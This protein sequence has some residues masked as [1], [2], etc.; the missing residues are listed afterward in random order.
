MA[1]GTLTPSGAEGVSERTRRGSDHPPFPVAMSKLA[2]PA[3]RRGSVIR[4][5]LIDRVRAHPDA[6]VV[7]VV[8]PA[9]YGKTTLLRQWADS[10][11]RPFKW[12][13]LDAHDNDP[14]VLLTGVALALEQIVPVEGDVFRLLHAPRH[15]V[16]SIVAE[17]AHAVDRVIGS[18]VLVLDD[19]HLLDDPECQ[20]IL[21]EVVNRLPP[22][23]QV[24]VGSR[25][26]PALPI[27]RLRA[28][29]RVVELGPSDLAMDDREAGQ[30]LTLADIDLG[31]EDIGALNRRVE[32]WPAALYLAAL[33]IAG[34]ADL[35]PTG[36][37]PVGTDR[38][39]VDYL[40]SEVLRRSAA[41]DVEFLVRTSLLEELSGSLCDAVLRTTGSAARLEALERCNLL[42][43]P[44]GHDRTWYRCH[45]L[46][47]EVLRAELHRRD[48]ELIAALRRRAADWYEAHAL[49][50][51]A[52]EQAMALGDGPRVASLATTWAQPFYQQGRA[53]TA[54]RWLDW[55]DEHDLVESRPTLGFTGA[56]AH[57][58]DGSPAAATRWLDAAQRAVTPQDPPAMRGHVALI[59]ALACEDGL[60]ATLRDAEQ[61]VALVPVEDPYRGLSLLVFGIA[62]LLTRQSDQADAVLADAVEIAED[63]GARPAAAIALAECALLALRNGRVADARD[64]ADR[65]CAAVAEAGL[66]GYGIS[67]L[68]YATAARVHL[69]QGDVARAESALVQAQRLQAHLNHS[70][71]FYTVQVRLEMARCYISLTDVSGA[72]TM[73]QEAVAV[74]RRRPALGPLVDEIAALQHQLD[75]LRT[76]MAGASALTSAEL[77][78]L[79]LLATYLSFREIGARL[80]ISPNTVKTEAISI[81]RKLGVSS[82]SE[83]VERAQQLGLLAGIDAS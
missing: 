17:L 44:L 2:P 67:A 15:S 19:L 57:M 72:R 38:F 6:S 53:T 12:L 68:M 33:A 82:R 65:A 18:A 61:A 81:Y 76:N 8:A 51:L 75:S 34:D 74:V 47:R 7:S 27:A 62:R 41:D 42:V 32:G 58:V 60:E 39:L 80:F 28:E 11:P 1:E 24:A 22:A 78:L 64:F 3:T 4:S 20:D 83:A 26:E 25:A 5:A 59:R 13:A 9:G 23:W 45:H 46:F 36:T 29:G 31:A 52:V 21:A 56:L 37:W 70:L 43:M 16:D 10:D 73:L 71:P 55:L 77:R 30:L 35:D 48:G 14:T 79:P 40:Q 66:D 69:E 54:R 50:E 49:P 63:A